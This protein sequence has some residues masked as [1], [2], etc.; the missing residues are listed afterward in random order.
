MPQHTHRDQPI[1][2]HQ[3]H[4]TIHKAH[5]SQKTCV[6]ETDGPAPFSRHR[7]TGLWRWRWRERNVIFI[8]RALQRPTLHRA[9]TSLLR[10]LLVSWAD[11]SICACLY[12]SVCFFM[13]SSL[14]S[15]STLPSTFT[16]Y[17][18]SPLSI[19]THAEFLLFYLSLHTTPHPHCCNLPNS[20]FLLR[21]PYVIVVHF[22]ML[23]S[24]LEHPYFLYL[25]YSLPLLH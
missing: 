12:G 10:G 23:Y 17:R 3:R 24:F 6:Q 15:A 22:A 4:R 13:C 9:N 19:K 11:L 21:M 2:S 25:Y 1:F 14:R 20:L 8:A 5:T 18:Q 16:Q 7:P